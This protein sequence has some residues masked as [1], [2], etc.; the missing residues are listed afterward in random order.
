MELVGLSPPSAAAPRHLEQSARYLRIRHP[1]R[2]LPPVDEVDH[3]AGEF[4]A[5]V[6]LQEVPAAGDRAVRLPCGA[7]DALA[8]TRRRRRG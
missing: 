8:A 2:R 3:H 5:L 7:G 1:V 4:A 6:L